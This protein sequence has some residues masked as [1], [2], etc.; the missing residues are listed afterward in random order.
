MKII[1]PKSSVFAALFNTQKCH[2]KVKKAEYCLTFDCDDGT[3]IYNNLSKELI[4][5]SKEES[6]CLDNINF[7]NSEITEYLIENWFYIDCNFDSKQL[8]D[9]FIATISLFE[10]PAPKNIYS[11]FTIMTTL[12][13]NARCFY[14]F[15]KE[16]IHP[17]MTK[18]TAEDIANFIITHTKED[19]KISLAWFGG[20]PLYNYEVIDII[21]NILKKAERE[22]TSTIITNGYLFADNLI[23]KAIDLWNL[24]RAQIT[25]DGTEKIY[26]TTKNYIYSDDNSPFATVINNIEKLLEKNI[27][28]T[29]R[30]N[31]GLHN[32][33]DLYTLVDYLVEKFSKYKK[34]SIYAHRLYNYDD[35]GNQIYD[36]NKTKRM[37]D[38]FMKFTEYLVKKGVY[39]PGILKSEHGFYHCMADNDK[40]LVVT[41]EGNLT[42]CEH[43]FESEII[44][45]IYSD[46][47]DYNLI[48]DWKKKVLPIELCNEC[49][50][51]ASCI[52]LQKCP[53]KPLGCDEFQRDE[54]IFHL[55]QKILSTYKKHKTKN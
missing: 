20:E 6:K 9:Q 37:I 43:Y 51:Y 45:N 47:L 30:L 14:C 24:K 49:P 38:A 34:F 2:A 5:L 22:F 26:N 25:L 4:L 46:N 50:V 27:S 7:S 18:K 1:V 17:R 16:R 32:V 15:Q 53:D 10:K 3:L 39:N 52:N 35:F 21:A 33:D 55:K 40:S 36:E 23:E 19:K 11:G 13:C 31:L 28:V 29:V 48:S 8:C 12:E 42:K 44:G 54:N 41:P